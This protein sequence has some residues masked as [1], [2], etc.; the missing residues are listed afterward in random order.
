MFSTVAE[1]SEKHTTALGAEE[2]QKLYEE[3]LQSN[4]KW[5]SSS[6][7]IQLQQSTEHVKFGANR[8]MTFQQLTDKYGSQ[9]TAQNIV[10]E[11]LANPQLANSQ[12]KRHPDCPKRD[13]T[14]LNDLT[15]P[16]S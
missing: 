5:Q 3:R 9:D 14:Q 8:W 6:Y 16:K 2:M 15:L 4:E 7:V 12:V 1:G 13:E 10:D 11:K